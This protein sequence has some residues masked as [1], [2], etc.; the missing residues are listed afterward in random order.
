FMAQ[1]H[2]L[3]PAAVVE[4]VADGAARG[5]REFHVRTQL[6]GI[7]SRTFGPATATR[8]LEALLAHRD[9]L[10]ALD[11]AGDEARWPG[12]LFRD[13]FRRGRDA[14][15]HITVHAGESA[16]PTSVWQAV[17]E[18]GAERLGHA[19][20]AS[21]DPALLDYLAE[22]RIGIESCLT[23]NVQTSTVASYAQHPLATYLAHGL[24]ATINTDDP[25]ISGI[26]LTHELTVAAPAAHLSPALIR[27]AQ[28][29]ALAVAFLSEA[30]K[31]Q[32]VSPS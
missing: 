31:A 20:R 16:G 1:A 3:D 10:V 4:A 5:Q 12:S 24:L 6:I 28:A 17:R 30:E 7:M 23:S 27:R 29:N 21:E 11:I 22:Q 14:G 15:W 2:A 26:T 19:V 18:L 8:E 32:L 25:A 13:H 9:K